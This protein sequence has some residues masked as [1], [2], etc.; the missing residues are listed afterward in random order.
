MS[1]DKLGKKT[2]PLLKERNR[3]TSTKGIVKFK[4]RLRKHAQIL[5]RKKAT[6]NAF[7]E[8]RKNL[9]SLLRIVK[10]FVA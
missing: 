8:E 6:N 2:F 1:Q 9:C 7:V 5:E 3:G 10:Y 4:M